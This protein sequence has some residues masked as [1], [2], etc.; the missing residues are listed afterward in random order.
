MRSPA[1]RTSPPAQ[2]RLGALSGPRATLRRAN[3]HNAAVPVPRVVLDRP[4]RL[5]GR[6]A[7]RG[8]ANPFEREN[9][10][11][12][13]LL[14]VDTAS[15]QVLVGDSREEADLL[16]SL[17][18]SPYAD[19]WITWGEHTFGDGFG[20]A[21][22]SADLGGQSDVLSVDVLYDEGEKGLR[23]SIPC[24]SQWQ[25]RACDRYEGVSRDS[26]LNAYAGALL[27]R[28]TDRHLF[29]TANP[30]LLDERGNAP[31]NDVNIVS[32][33]EALALV[34]LL[35]RQRGRCDLFYDASG[36]FERSDAARFY[37]QLADVLAAQAH[38]L[39]D[40]LSIPGAVP[41]DTLDVLFAVDNRIND[42]L[43]ARDEVRIAS[44]LPHG[45]AMLSTALYHIRGAVQTALALLESVAVLADKHFGVGSDELS[46][47]FR[48]SDFRKDL[49][50]AGAADLAMLVSGQPYLSLSF[51]VS[52]L[53]GSIG[54]GGGLH[55]VTDVTAPEVTSGVQLD[56]AQA[57]KLK[58]V[59]G[60]RRDAPEEW[61]VRNAGFSLVNA[62]TFM[63]KLVRTAIEVFH[64]TAAALER[65]F[66][67]LHPGD[68]PLIRA[69]RESNE[70]AERVRASMP[71]GERA[72]L[73][74]REREQQQGEAQ[75]ER[76][77][78]Q[79]LALYG[80]FADWEL[81]GQLI[82]ARTTV[83]AA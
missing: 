26:A 35:M 79:H 15:V 27:T 7:H 2:R 22:L 36:P 69:L 56:E 80:G 82:A 41:D 9:Y 83:A 48:R 33:R 59:C 54:H 5:T 32:T 29:V 12:P 19:I 47:S 57:K 73:E 34:S 24:W 8:P 76:E 52:E 14:V 62:E 17:G 16:A 67:R 6:S 77:V 28:T 74:R 45:G 11:V 43:V 39:G 50:S 42:L 60:Q 13:L 10:D 46:T 25:Q 78:L 31:W 18:H 66:R 55:G 30:P 53:R 40:V 70:R 63:D 20:M 72:E 49:D 38:E 61:G 65:D 51:F 68:S 21:Q 3:P 58:Q 75:A 44:M 81:L 1:V 37:F 4:V 71:K 23:T 64:E